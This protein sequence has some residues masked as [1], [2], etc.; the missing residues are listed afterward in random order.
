MAGHNKWSSI[1]HKKAKTD[2]QKGKIFSKLAREIMMATKLGGQDPDMNPR[3]RLA[4]QNAK[5]ANMPN[6][7]IN[8]AIQKGA[9]G[10]DDTNLTEIEYEAYA[11]HGVG[12]IIKTLTD[13][14]NRT[15]SNVRTIVNKSGG[16]MAE[17]GAVSYLFETKGL[18]ILENN[19]DIDKIIDIAIENGAD[20]VERKDDDSIEITCE[21]TF[22]EQIKTN[23]EKEQLI[24]STATITKIP[25]TYITISE[26]DATK[27]LSLIENLEDDDD[28]QEI[29]ANFD[30][31]N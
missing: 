27:I 3:L 21:P 1:K 20:D 14:V 28:V 10:G 31:Q 5:S 25:S 17:K 15:I 11:Q 23:L 12:I 26:D 6:D 13:N 2:A 4:L 29:F 22:F 8:R 7:N 30:I 9:G 16:N 19:T 18:I 24:I